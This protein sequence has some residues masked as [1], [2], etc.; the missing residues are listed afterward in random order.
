MK[1]ILFIAIN[2]LRSMEIN[3]KKPNNKKLIFT[4]RFKK[5]KKE[6]IKG[7]VDSY[8]T[9][10]PNPIDD[11]INQDSPPFIFPVHQADVS[12]IFMKNRRFLKISLRV[13]LVF[14]ISKKPN[15][16]RYNTLRGRF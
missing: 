5:E 11:L 12:N 16:K 9:L 6:Y 1:R 7:L 3:I 14:K 8:N 2:I 13:P 15:Q 4:G 10:F